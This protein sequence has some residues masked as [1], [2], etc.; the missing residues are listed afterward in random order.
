VLGFQPYVEAARRSANFIADELVVD[1]SL[2]HTWREGHGASVPAF[3]EDVGYLAQALLVL[4]EADPDPRWVQW[5]TE[6]ADDAEARFAD[7]ET[8]TYYTT[9]ED[10][11][12]PLTRPKELFDNA[13]PA[14]VSTLADACLRLAGLTGELAYRERAQR[15]FAAFAPH[16]TR[17]P[18]GYGEM[19]R[20]LERFVGDPRELAIVGAPTA[21]ETKALAGVYRETWHPATVLAVG[22]PDGAQGAEGA[23]HTVP[24]LVGRTLVEGQPAAY[25]CRGF[26][27]DRPVTSPEE[28]RPALDG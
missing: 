23:G 16:L 3:L 9:A 2:R 25:V 8:G 7:G 14:G 19:L 10:A 4:Y 22:E 13:Q 21:P 15:M 1:G 6:L 20:A 24:L 11:E 5:A 26:A 18:T 17:A 12:A 27:C 28:L